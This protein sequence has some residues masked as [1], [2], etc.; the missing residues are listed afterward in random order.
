MKL[1]VKILSASL[2]PFL[3]IIGF[4]HFLTTETFSRHMD[5]MFRQQAVAKMLQ[6]EEDIQQFMH[7][8]ESHLKLLAAIS[9]PTEQNP[10]AAKMALANLL[11]TEESFFRISAVNIRGQEWLRINKFPTAHEDEELEN[12]FSSPLYQ[13]PMLELTTFWGNVSWQQ[14][15]PLPMLDITIPVKQKLTGKISGILWGRLSLQGVQTILERF[16]PVNGKLML[17]HVSSGKTLVK[18]DDTKHNFTKLEAKALQEVLH[19]EGSMGI[20]ENDGDKGLLSCGYRKFSVDDMEF[21]LLYFQPNE[22]IYYLADRLKI[23]NLYVT[24]AG[25]LLFT[26]ASF[27]LIGR[28][29]NPLTSLTAMIG[30]LGRKYHSHVDRDHLDQVALDQDGD[31]VDRLRAAFS[32]FEARLAS[33][34][35]EIE[36]FNKTLEQQVA[37]K[38]QELGDVNLTLEADIKQRQLA[39]AELKKHRANLERIVAERTAELSRINKELQV[40]IKERIHADGA[41]RAKSEFLANMSHEI[42]TPMNAIIGMNRLA[43]DTTLSAKQQSY[44]TAVQ[45]SAESLLN[46]INDILDFSKIEAGQLALDEHPFQLSKLC[47]SIKKTFAVKVEEKK[48]K[49]HSDIASDIPMFLVGDEFR[50]R[51]ILVNLFGNALKFTET[52]EIRLKIIKTAETDEQLVLQFTVSDSGPGIPHEFQDRLFNSFTQVDSSVTRLHGGTGL[53]LAICKKIT[54]LMGGRIWVESELGHGASFHFTV[55]LKKDV[56]PFQDSFSLGLSDEDEALID[57]YENNPSLRVLLVEDNIFN[58]DLA[59]IILENSGHT[60]TTAEDGLKAL[61]IL[62]NEKFDVVLMDVQMPKMDGITATKLIRSC[63]NG[64]DVIY[65]EENKLMGKLKEKTH[66]GHVM[67]IAMTANA[68]AGDREK[69][70]DAGMDSYITKPFEPVELIETLQRIAVG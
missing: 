47:D 50:L 52:G 64:E 62:S 23:Y 70:L 16:L 58:Q 32:F 41:S 35:V 43:L 40:E 10:I 26:M 54:E 53:G 55:L 65:P 4:Y 61:K 60:V 9:P 2:L 15:Y 37:E 11:Q 42:R 17:V 63:E 67:I 25:I 69:C 22:T 46:I 49:L 14:G 66:G 6:A 5:D 18:A 3:V 13:Q 29:I 1:S 31:E 24:L 38:T 44:L 39:E 27:L 59:R 45:E 8:S 7:I 28:I 20:L 33:Y 48:I 51:Q 57:S 21:V 68:M 36:G 19:R 56:A 34:S 30:D 12:L